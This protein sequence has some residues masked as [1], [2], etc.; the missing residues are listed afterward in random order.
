[1]KGCKMSE[2]KN[3]NENKS[4]NA[5]LSLREIERERSACR[6]WLAANGGDKLTAEARET[7]EKKLAFS[8]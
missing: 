7:A 3:T 1:M 6:E 5:A 8:G 2:N 4:E